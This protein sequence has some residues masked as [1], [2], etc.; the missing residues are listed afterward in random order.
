MISHEVH[1][2]SSGAS[3]FNWFRDVKSQGSADV[4]R[5][6]TEERFLFGDF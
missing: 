5:S 6:G 2:S 4:N 3:F 1:Y